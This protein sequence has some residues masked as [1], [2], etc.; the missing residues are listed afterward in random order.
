MRV[1]RM[2]T[3]RWMVAVA[4]VGLMMGVAI[5]GYRLKW[6][7]D[8]FQSRALYHDQM[9][10]AYVFVEPFTRDLLPIYDNLMKGL[11]EQRAKQRQ[12]GDERSAFELD[13]KQA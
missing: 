3:R 9:E 1:P 6:R 8:Y 4:I 7:Y 11:A 2:T 5:V 12:A 10:H 13:P